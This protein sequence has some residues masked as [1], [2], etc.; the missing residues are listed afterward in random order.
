MKYAILAALLFVPLAV[1]GSYLSRDP[2]SAEAPKIQLRTVQLPTAEPVAKAQPKRKPKARKHQRRPSTVHRASADRT[3]A[4]S[5]GGGTDDDDDDGAAR[6]SGGAARS[7][8][9]A[10]PVPIPAPA[11]A[12]VRG[13]DQTADR[14]GGAGDDTADGGAEGSGSDGDD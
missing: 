12:G 7:S 14:G 11:R 1:A 5:R 6:S 2:T 13:D 3:T 4:P 9:G 8:R 10:A